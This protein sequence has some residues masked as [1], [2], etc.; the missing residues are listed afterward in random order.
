MASKKAKKIPKL[1]A[2][3]VK[4]PRIVKVKLA[5]ISRKSFK[6]H[7][8]FV[9]YSH[10]NERYIEEFKNFFKPASD[11]SIFYDSGIEEGDEWELKIFRAIDNCKVAILFL[12]VAFLASEYI[13]NKELPRLIA[14]VR[15]GEIKLYIMYVEQC[16]MRIQYLN[17]RSINL[18]TILIGHLREKVLLLTKE[19]V[20]II[21]Y[22]RFLLRSF[23][24]LDMHKLDNINTNFR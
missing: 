19:I 22:Q 5:P 21:N 17:L 1:R 15:K 6:D 24:N 9:S 3:S 18:S 16:Y 23:Y 7:F 4:T 12:S 2:P 13:M 14:R 11:I 8:G 10:K 20:I